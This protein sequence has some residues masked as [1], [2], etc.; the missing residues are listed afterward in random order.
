MENK[1]KNFIEKHCKECKE[2]CE[3]GLT[4]INNQIKC[5]DTGIVEKTKGENKDGK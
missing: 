3:K 1:F 2:N 5:G 4:L